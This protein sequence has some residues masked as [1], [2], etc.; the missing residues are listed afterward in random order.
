MRGINREGLALSE[1]TDVD[2]TTLK[3]RVE[4]AIRDEITVYGTK[5]NFDEV[6]IVTDNTRLIGTV[7]EAGG[8]TWVK[9][10]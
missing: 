9:E 5:L 8:I 3:G 1:E 7:D 10:R 6:R 2:K 4:K